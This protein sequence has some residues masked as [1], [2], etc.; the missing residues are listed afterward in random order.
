MSP[1]DKRSMSHAFPPM[2]VLGVPERAQIT[3]ASAMSAR[4]V[5]RHV[6]PTRWCTEIAKCTRAHPHLARIAEVRNLQNPPARPH[7]NMSDEGQGGQRK[8]GATQ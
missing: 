5:H 4:N 8:E 2:A 3:R 1:I 6:E 7:P